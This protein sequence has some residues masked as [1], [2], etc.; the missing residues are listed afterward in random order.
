MYNSYIIFLLCPSRFT[1]YQTCS[2][3]S[4]MVHKDWYF[5]FKISGLSYMELGT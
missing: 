3:I 4:E 5:K 1:Q 2:Q